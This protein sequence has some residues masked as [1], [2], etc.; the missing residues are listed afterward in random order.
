MCNVSLTQLARHTPSALLNL[1]TRTNENKT[2]TRGHIKITS[3]VLSSSRSEVVMHKA[4]LV[5]CAVLVAC[6]NAPEPIP[7]AVTGSTNFAVTGLG[8]AQASR[9]S[10]YRVSGLA[11]PAAGRPLVIYL[12]G[13][14]SSN[15]QVPSAYSAWTDQ[16]A[17]VLVAPQ[18]LDATWRFR[19]DGKNNAGSAAEV[20]D[21]AF[22][23][24][25]ITRA[26]NAATPLFGAGN[27][28]DPAK[29]FVVGES[30]G[31]GLAYYLYA[32][33]RT[34]NKISA[35][36]P[37]SGTFFC[38]TS[39][40]GNGTLPYNPPPDSD[41]NCGENG[42]FGYFAPKANLYVRTNAPRVFA[43]HGSN[44]FPETAAPALDNEFGTLILMTKQWAQTSS[45]CGASLPSA[46]PVFANASIAG[47]FVS[48]YR[49]R[50]QAG[51]A[52]CPA[53]VTFFIVQGG[54]H[55]PGGYAER[56]V[57]W[58]FGQYNTQTNTLSP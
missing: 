21:V 20:D 33:P 56:I 12:H 13:D 17:A 44:D 40:S 22:I 5:L 4:M 43:I 8:A 23:A 18:G 57:K 51:N 45:N 58:F 37:L 25:I 26:S 14:T 48:A 9:T 39:N 19:M 34:K 10:Q 36:A 55:V 15:T 27:T 38:A 24:E 31:A 2:A 30:R 47:R 11:A 42:G 52:P 3:L 54:G 16:Q 53:D 32:D 49:Q 1:A 28:I 46:S 50:N 35:I 29:V 41:L 6:G 7:G